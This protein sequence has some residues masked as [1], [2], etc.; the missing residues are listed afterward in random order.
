MRRLS[1][2]GLWLLLFIA[3]A[4][5]ADELLQPED[6]VYLGAF[7]LPPG[8]GEQQWNYGGWGSRGSA[9]LAC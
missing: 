4:A 5:R 3:V 6:L 7:R 9:C 1:V 8:E 2:V